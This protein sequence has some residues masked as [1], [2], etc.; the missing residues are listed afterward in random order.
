ML[1]KKSK[2]TIFETQFSSKEKRAMDAEIQKQLGEYDRKH[3]IEL[4]AI[5]LWELHDQYGWGRKKLKK[6]F[7]SFAPELE[8]LIKRY[9]FE[10]SD[11]I[12]LCTHM[13]NEIGIDVEAWHK[14]RGS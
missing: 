7:D 6:F 2:G 10:D 12:W 4:D 3:T 8:A 9:D 11:Q 13:L 5:V 1:F 14:K